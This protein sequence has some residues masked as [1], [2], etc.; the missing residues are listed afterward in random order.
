MAIVVPAGML[1]G[2]GGR[3]IAETTG[4]DG[5]GRGAPAVAG[6]TVVVTSSFVCPAAGGCTNVVVVFPALSTDTTCCACPVAAA[7]FFAWSSAFSCL[8]AH[9]ERSPAAITKTSTGTVAV[10]TNK[11]ELNMSN[12]L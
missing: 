8:D 12:L 7:A 4:A 5:A 2:G 9:P 3:G 1:T 6:V 11:R 10:R